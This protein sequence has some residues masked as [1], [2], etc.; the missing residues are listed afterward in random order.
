MSLTFDAAT[1]VYTWHEQGVSRRLVSV[2]D[3]LRRAGMVDA[4]WFTDEARERGTQVHA[5]I[6]RDIAGMSDRRTI[7]LPHVIQWRR[8]LHDSGFVPAESEQPVCDPIA[9]YAGTFDVR[10]WFS[11]DPSRRVLLDIKTGAIPDWC[12]LQLA[13]YARCVPEPHRRM[14]VA[15][16]ETTY[17]TTEYR[18]RADERLFLAAC[19]VAVWQVQ[20]GL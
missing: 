11:A 5:A 15:L 16:T 13:A 18:N 19:A 1:H 3:V 6:A 14:G 20:H 17:T 4:R 9:G 10:G 12:G 8:F 7:V 2:T